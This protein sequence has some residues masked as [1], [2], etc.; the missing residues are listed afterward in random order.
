VLRALSLALKFGLELAAFAA[1]AFWGTSV[2]RGVLSVLV[3]IA[4]PA[5]AIVLWARFAAP[6]SERRLPTAPRVA[7]EV[8]V[9]ALAVVALAVAG[10]VPAAIV[11]AV[12]VAASTA[13]LTALDQWEA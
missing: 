12:L 7:F 1:F 13:L 2:G 8:S 11:L 10:A 5:L 6:R 4:A 3:A 9:F